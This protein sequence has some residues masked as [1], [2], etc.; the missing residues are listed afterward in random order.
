MMI[1]T[2]LISWDNGATTGPVY[3]A[4]RNS[5]FF[6]LWN[7]KNE[8]IANISSTGFISGH[9]VDPK[10]LKVVLD[11]QSGDSGPSLWTMT[12][13]PTSG[14]PTAVTLTKSSVYSLATFQTFKGLP[15]QSLE[16]NAYYYLA[17]T[18]GG[19]DQSVYQVDNSGG[20][21]L[22]YTYSVD[23]SETKFL[24]IPTSSAQSCFLYLA[25]SYV[26]T[27]SNTLSAT[28]LYKANLTNINTQKTT[29]STPGGAN[30]APSTNFAIL[31]NVEEKLLYFIDQYSNNIVTYF[32]LFGLNTIA[33][34]KGLTSTTP[35]APL[36]SG[37]YLSAINMGSLV[38]LVGISQDSTYGWTA[39][40]YSKS[41]LNQLKGGLVLQNDKKS[42]Y[43][44]TGMVYNAFQQTGA[45]IFVPFGTLA[46]NTGTETAYQN[47]LTNISFIMCPFQVYLSLKDG[48]CYEI[49]NFP[50]NQGN[51]SVIGSVNY[52]IDSCADANCL[53]CVNTTTV[54]V[55]CN[56]GYYVDSMSGCS[57]CPL[58]CSACLSQTTCT[59]CSSGYTLSGGSCTVASSGNNSTVS[60]STGTGNSTGN[61]SSGNSGNGTTGGSNSK[62]V[63]YGVGLGVAIGLGVP[64]FAGGVSLLLAKLGV[65]SKFLKPPVH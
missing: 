30:I 11:K 29:L 65:F 54:C 57:L 1:S 17:K 16:N 31:D 60:N 41:G 40:I 10:G 44:A 61:G 15:M 22:S 35:I 64:A 58:N 59:N 33:L 19:A 47:T 49:K 42:P 25:Y 53:S 28:Y 9:L 50:A 36:V 43:P 37:Q 63:S 34:G 18:G 23:P 45:N 46:S 52:T 39:S 14:A 56:S 51:S 12:Y 21:S 4:E 20:V 27:T 38:L 5:V 6:V 2:N 62:A 3:S 48:N 24:L 13:A 32:G 26:G 55:Q 7:H 8:R